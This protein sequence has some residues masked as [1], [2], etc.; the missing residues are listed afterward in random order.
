MKPAQTVSSVSP[1]VQQHN[2]LVYNETE[3]KEIFTE[4]KLEQMQCFPH[5]EGS[6]PHIMKPNNVLI[7]D[8]KLNGHIRKLTTV[9]RTAAV[10]RFDP[11]SE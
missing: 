9:R 6:C 3:K 5:R 1:T 11:N 10:H 7:R 4:E 8:V 2:D